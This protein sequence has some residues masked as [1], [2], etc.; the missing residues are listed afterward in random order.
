MVF[1]RDRIGTFIWIDKLLSLLPL[2]ED[3]G[4]VVKKTGALRDK[5][6]RC[7]LCAIAHTIDTSNDWYAAALMSLHALGIGLH[8]EAF[9]NA[10][11]AITSA[12]DGWPR[13]SKRVRQRLLKALQPKVSTR[14]TTELNVRPTL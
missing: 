9:Q 5:E 14:S 11:S 12:A 3:R 8:D 13:A 7:P 1:N 4:W 6:D 2:I 10:V